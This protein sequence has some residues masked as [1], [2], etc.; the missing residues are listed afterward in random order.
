MT[1]TGRPRVR[2]VLPGVLA[3]CV[4]PLAA[5]EPVVSFD[6]ADDAVVL[7]IGDARVG[8]YVL[9]DAAVPRPY[10]VDLKTLGGRQVTRVHPPREGQDAVD[11]PGMHTGLWLSFGDLNGNDYW[12]LKARTEHV[13]FVEDPKG[14]AGRGGFVARNRYLAADGKSAVAEEDF[15]CTLRTVRHGYRLDLASEFRPLDSELAFGD[16][17]EMGL[18]IRVAT[19]LA[20][21]R[22][23]GGR[24]LDSAGRRNGAEVWGKT[25]DWCDYSGTI[26]GQ[27]VGLTILCH[28]KNFRASWC[29]ARDYGLLVLNP[30]GR[31]AFTKQDASRVVVKNGETFTLRYT[32]VVHESPAES[33][34]DPGAE[35]PS[36]K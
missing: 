12:R 21:D 4:S 18:G 7:R 5:G 9:R 11:H 1:R 31:R 13:R 14:E 30:F 15:R 29:H 35:T 20:V 36:A 23:Q 17:E 28:P 26:D 2:I 16:Q 6:R 24:I 27:W 8:R 22:K 25:A 33:D 19:P 10:F 3:L 32:V 34:Y